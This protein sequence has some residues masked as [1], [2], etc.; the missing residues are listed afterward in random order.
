MVQRSIVSNKLLV[1]FLVAIFA[2]QICTAVSQPIRPKEAY[3]YDRFVRPTSR[4]VWQQ[5][6]PNRDVL[7]TLLEK[8][9]VGLFHV[10]PFS[11][12]LPGLLFLILYLWSAWRLAQLIPGTWLRFG[13]V[14]LASLPP[15]FWP[16]F[17]TAEGT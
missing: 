16:W 17:T 15:L 5:E 11:V 1:A 14:L 2:V 10:S 3:L 9:S 6:L 12:R 4:Q 8:R 7:Y 13:A